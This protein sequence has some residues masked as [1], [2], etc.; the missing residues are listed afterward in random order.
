MLKSGKTLSATARAVGNMHCPVQLTASVRVIAGVYH[1]QAPM[2]M[3]ANLKNG[4]AV[5]TVYIH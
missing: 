5:V 2:I 3:I 1:I 4:C